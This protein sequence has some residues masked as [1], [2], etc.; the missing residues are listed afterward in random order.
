MTMAYSSGN[1]NFFG[2]ILKV[3]S[4]AFDYLREKHKPLPPELKELM[5]DIQLELIDY[6]RHNQNIN[7]DSDE[8]KQLLEFDNL[9]D[10]ILLKSEELE[11]KMEVDKKEEEYKKARRQLRKFKESKLTVSPLINQSK[12]KIQR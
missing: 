6:P 11:L 4:D 2:E 7:P 1:S 8:M 9:I 5:Y 3:L 10:L 12:V